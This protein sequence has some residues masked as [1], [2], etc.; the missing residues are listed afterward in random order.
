MKL[1]KEYGIL[2]A[3][4]FPFS[5]LSI[6]FLFMVCMKKTARVKLNQFLLKMLYVF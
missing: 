1:D 2:N 3:V 6:V 4:S 5:S